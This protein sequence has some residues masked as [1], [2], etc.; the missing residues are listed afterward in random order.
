MARKRGD[1][2]RAGRG[3]AVHGDAAAIDLAHARLG[4]Y[5]PRRAVRDHAAV[6]EENEPTAVLGGKVQVVRHHRH[7]EP[8]IPVL[9]AQPIVEVESVA[10]VE[11]RSRCRVFNG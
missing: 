6:R 9:L 10:D 2:R 5:L 1:A 3:I 8:A 4:E 11:E 7:G